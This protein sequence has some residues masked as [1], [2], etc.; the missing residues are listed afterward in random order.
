MQYEWDENKRIANFARHNVDFAD[1]VDF[2]WDTA[3]ETIDDRVPGISVDE[4]LSINLLLG[5]NEPVNLIGSPQVTYL[6]HDRSFQVT[7]GGFFQV[8]LPMAER[9][10]D[11]VLSLLDLQGLA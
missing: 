4:P 9:L 11:R 6:V 7:A 1:A 3:L 2:E 8:N 10:V 5:D